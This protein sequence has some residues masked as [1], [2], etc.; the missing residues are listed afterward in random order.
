MFDKTLC[1]PLSP[2][3][4]FGFL[5]LVNCIFVEGRESIIIRGAFFVNSKIEIVK[6]IFFTKFGER[7]WYRFGLRLLICV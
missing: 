1:F 3:E 6:I 5:Y 7:I 2:Q 4:R